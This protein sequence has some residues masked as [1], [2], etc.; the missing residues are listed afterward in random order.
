MSFHE[1]SRPR[2][3]PPTPRIL[4]AAIFKDSP[5]QPNTIV[6]FSYTCTVQMLLKARTNVSVICTDH[7][8]GACAAGGWKSALLVDQSGNRNRTPAFNRW[9]PETSSW[10]LILSFWGT[11]NGQQ[12]LLLKIHSLFSFRCRNSFRRDCTAAQFTANLKLTCKASGS[13]LCHLSFCQVW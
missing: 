3:R 9:K 11:R 6:L 1:S 13:C 4:C 5:P 8:S 10:G 2:S 12:G 7:V